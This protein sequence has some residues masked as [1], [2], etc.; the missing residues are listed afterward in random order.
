MK[1]M[2]HIIFAILV[3]REKRVKKRCFHE[4]FSNSK[5]SDQVHQNFHK[6]TQF[7]AHIYHSVISCLPT[8]DNVSRTIT[9]LVAMV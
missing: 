3:V 9:Y 7:V 1:N 6:M 5:C 4:R 8:T 2:I